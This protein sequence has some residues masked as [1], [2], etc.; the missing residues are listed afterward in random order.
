MIEESVINGILGKLGEVDSTLPKY[1]EQTEQSIQGPAFF[2]LQINSSQ[3][4]GMNRRYIRSLSYNIHFFP[5]PGSLTKKADCRSMGERLYTSLENIAVNGRLIRARDM[6]Y[7][8]VEDVLHFFVSF[9]VHLMKERPE[10]VKMQKLE[11]R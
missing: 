4:K 10:G 6:K 2:V 1:M 11:R 8:V 9:D 7:E 3:T 5:D